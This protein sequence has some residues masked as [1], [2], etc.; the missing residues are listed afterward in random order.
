MVDKFLKIVS[1][2]WRN[3]IIPASAIQR[4]ANPPVMNVNA[5]IVC[6]TSIDM[7]F[8]INAEF[9]ANPQANPVKAVAAQTMWASFCHR[10]VDLS[11]E[12]MQSQIKQRRF[13]TKGSI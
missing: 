1:I 2:L 4:A 6:P 8:Q 11:A 7:N 9:D 5:Y 12:Q 3:K 10:L 13:V